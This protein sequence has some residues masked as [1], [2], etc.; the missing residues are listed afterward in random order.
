MSKEG[1][2]QERVRERERQREQETG[3][4]QEEKNRNEEEKGKEKNV[5]KRGKRTLT[6]FKIIDGLHKF[7]F[8]VPLEFCKCYLRHC[9]GR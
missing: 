7:L 1:T 3:K 5:R 2:K 6:F 9:M 8:Y 4:E